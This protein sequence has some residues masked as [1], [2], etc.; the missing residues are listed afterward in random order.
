MGS[1]RYIAG[2]TLSSDLESYILQISLAAIICSFSW[3]YHSRS[4]DQLNRQHWYPNN[5][6]IRK[7]L[8]MLW[9]VSCWLIMELGANSVKATIEEKSH[10]HG[11]TRGISE[12]S[13]T[14]P[15]SI[16]SVHTI[17]KSLN[18]IILVYIPTRLSFT[19][20]N[21]SV[22]TRHSTYCWQI[23]LQSSMEYTES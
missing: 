12:L 21:S 2:I 19:R 4:L 8:Q 22:Y 23:T 5:P 1:L 20:T 3:S 6:S 18:P 14:I 13:L 17:L 10:F 15:C 7:N 16:P 9:T 11:G